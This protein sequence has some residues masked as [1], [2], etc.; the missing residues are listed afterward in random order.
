[1]VTTDT[2]LSRKKRKVSINSNSMRRRDCFTQMRI[3]TNSSILK[4]SEGA[5]NIKRKKRRKIQVVMKDS[6]ILAAEG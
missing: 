6:N 1:M 5:D 4:A 2:A 3:L